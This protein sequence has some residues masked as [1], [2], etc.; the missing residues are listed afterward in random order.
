MAS[1]LRDQINRYEKL[2]EAEIEE[3]SKLSNDIDELYKHL[4]QYI[5]YRYV[6]ADEDYWS[7]NI[8]EL[9]KYS[10][11]KLIDLQKDEPLQDISMTCTG[12][13][14]A[15]TRK[16]L[17][18]MSIQKKLGFKFDYDEVPYIETVPQLAQAIA[19]YLNDQKSKSL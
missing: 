14:S 8:D 3:M 5:R 6:L 13:S 11:K 15:S 7:D 18:L 12:A 16:V 17:L 1:S 2:S 4:K 9:S 10:I 19:N